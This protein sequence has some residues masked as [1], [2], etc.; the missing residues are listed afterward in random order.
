M[1]LPNG[2][3]MSYEIKTF[4]APTGDG[5]DISVIK[6]E[7]KNAPVLKVGDSD[8]VSLQEH[9]TVLGYPGAADSDVLSKK[10]SLEASITD[11][12]VSAR[13]T[14]TD[15]APILQVARTND[16]RKLGGPV[17]NDN[18]EV[19]GLLTFRGNTVN[20]QE[21][22]GFSFVVPSNTAQEFVRQAGTTSQLGPTDPAYRDGLDLYFN[23][24]YTAAIAKFEEVKRLFPQ[25][26]EAD[27]LIR[28]SQESIA[29]GKDKPVTA[30]A[31]KKSSGNVGVLLAALAV[32]CSPSLW[33][34]SSSSSC[35]RD[36]P[37]L[38][39]TS[40]PLLV[41]PTCRQARPHRQCRTSLGR[42]GCR[43]S[44]RRANRD[45]GPYQPV[46]RYVPRRF[47]CALEPRLAEPG[48]CPGAEM[49]LGRLPD[50]EIVVPD[51][52]VSG[53][54]AQINRYQDG[55]YVLTDRQ[56]SNGTTVN[57]VQSDAAGGTAF[58]RRDRARRNRRL[59]LTANPE[60][61]D[62]CAWDI[63]MA[64]QPAQAPPLRAVGLDHA[65]GRVGNHAL[66]LRLGLIADCYCQTPRRPARQLQQRHLGPQVRQNAVNACLHGTRW[67]A[68]AS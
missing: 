39:Q 33:P 5:K 14:T 49:K 23:N 26:S 34:L 41:P 4:G 38:G 54:H 59:F 13:K 10:S 20:G 18:G 27:N 53:H 48:A 36:G 1:V 62:P 9:I 57:G 43:R 68:A 51:R 66:S 47:R 40:L 37:R 52:L 61:S 30:Q 17:L 16:A 11:G 15:G 35:A 19:V 46:W 45:C 22:Q 24:H 60:H 44:A 58:R 8:K 6:V 42:A 63:L 28:Q 21:V 25:H 65:P 31:A 12:K 3:T 32:F 2:A 50:N 29:A 67:H 55:R 56:S 7:V 64:P